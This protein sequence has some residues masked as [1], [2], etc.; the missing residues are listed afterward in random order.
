LLRLG[1]FPRHPSGSLYT[2]GLPLQDGHERIEGDW[3]G[4]WVEEVNEGF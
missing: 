4:R 2:L 1:R 3:H